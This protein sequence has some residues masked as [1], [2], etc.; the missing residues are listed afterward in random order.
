MTT[1]P[2]DT[3]VPAN[4]ARAASD[5]GSRCLCPSRLQRVFD[6]ET[7]RAPGDA[8]CQQECG[9]V[10]LGHVGP[11]RQACIAPSEPSVESY[12]RLYSRWALLCDATTPNHV[13]PPTV[14]ENEHWRQSAQN[15][16]HT[17]RAI[18]VVVATTN[19]LRWFGRY[20]VTLGVSSHSCADV[21]DGARELVPVGQGWL[22]ARQGMWLGRQS[23]PSRVS[24]TLEVL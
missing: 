21:G 1:S 23:E 12:S 8:P 2:R 13:R 9:Q 11:A 14:K 7:D 22:S 15:P 18:K 19:A 3:V 24:C 5:R 10:S 16:I 17:D 20:P 4:H 6:L